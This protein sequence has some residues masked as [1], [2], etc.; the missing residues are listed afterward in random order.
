MAAAVLSVAGFGVLMG[1]AQPGDPLYGAR[2]TLFGEPASVSDERIAVSAES[3]MDQVEQMI[4]TGQWDQAH[5]KLAAVGAHVQTV[6]DA[7]RKQG[8]TRSHEPVDR[9]GGESRR[10]CHG[11]AHCSRNRVDAQRFWSPRAT[12]RAGQRRPWNPSESVVAS[13]SEASA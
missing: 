1:Q 10:A 12:G 7:D 2:T 3:E 4:A 13:L 9:E 8:L 5:D 11:A 6:R